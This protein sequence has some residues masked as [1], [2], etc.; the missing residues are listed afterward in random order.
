MTAGKGIIHSEMPGP[1]KVNRGLQLWVNLAAADELCEPDYQELMKEDIPGALSSDGKTSVKVVAGE[2]FGVKSAVFTR[3]PTMFLDIIMQ[4][5]AQFEGLGVPDKYNA[6]IFVIEGS[7]K[8]AGH[9][10][11]GREGSCVLLGKGD[12]VSAVAGSQ[13]SRFV[14]I[15]GKPTGEKVFASGPFVLSSKER[16]N[17]A[18]DD[19]RAGKFS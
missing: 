9:E 11:N 18:F 2:A 15:G 1:G 13:G 4:P 19:Y 5:N 14:L 10:E 6:F 8:V 7:V 12:S 16:L 17:Q 3:T